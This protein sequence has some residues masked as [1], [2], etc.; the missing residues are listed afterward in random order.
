[1]VVYIER[2]TYVVISRQMNTFLLE[3]SLTPLIKMAILICNE[4]TIG[5]MKVEPLHPFQVK[6]F[7]ESYN[8]RKHI[9]D[10]IL[11]HKTLCKFSE[12]FIAMKLT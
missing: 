4:T 12:V 1:M 3:R 6:T 7:K 11:L 9:F 8:N 10:M 5:K 2:D